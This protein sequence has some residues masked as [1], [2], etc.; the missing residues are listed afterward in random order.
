MVVKSNCSQM[1]DTL[2]D[3]EECQRVLKTYK[4]RIM[5]S[6]NEKL[7]KFIIKYYDLEN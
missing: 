6:N 5:K 2:E 1:E 3:C 7:K 4:D